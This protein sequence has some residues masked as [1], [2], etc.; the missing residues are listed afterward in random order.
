MHLSI[1]IEKI[2]FDINAH[3][4]LSFLFYEAKENFLQDIDRIHNR[5]TTRY[6]SFNLEP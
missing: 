2:C 4:H 3:S 1:F 5:D 6:Q